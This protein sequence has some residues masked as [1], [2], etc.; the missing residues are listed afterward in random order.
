MME[1][2]HSFIQRTA[3]AR[4]TRVLKQKDFPID[5]IV[6][7][8]VLWRGSRP[9][10]LVLQDFQQKVD[11]LP[12]IVEMRRDAHGVMAVA[13]VLVDM[14]AV[15]LQGTRLE[16]RRLDPL[17]L[18]QRNAGGGNL[19]RRETDPPHPRDRLEPR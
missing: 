10:N 4:V 11:L 9:A 2:L 17:D 5:R 14:D 16:L 13:H 18:E 3:F 6:S 8:T 19:P 12:R 1:I 15:L 7:D